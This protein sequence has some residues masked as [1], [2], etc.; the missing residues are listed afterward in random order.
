MPQRFG[1]VFEA[2][3]LNSHS[4]LQHFS[5]IKPQPSRYARDASSASS[6]QIFP[7]YYDAELPVARRSVTSPL[8][9]ILNS[10]VNRR[11]IQG[12]PLHRNP[13]KRCAQ[14]TPARGEASQSYPMITYVSPM[15]L[16]AH[17]SPE[18]SGRLDCLLGFPLEAA[19]LPLAVLTLTVIIGS[20][21]P[22]VTNRSRLSEDFARRASED[23]CAQRTGGSEEQESLNSRT[24]PGN[25]DHDSAEGLRRNR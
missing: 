23:G 7:I 16:T 14:Q 9:V 22:S 10:W 20:V 2:D 15:D 18:T 12:S 21:N 17:V 11:S 4:K 19:C 24:I 25:S 1:K 8:W 5:A 6:L 13:S 3:L